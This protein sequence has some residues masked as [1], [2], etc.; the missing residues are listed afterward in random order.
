MGTPRWFLVV[1]TIC[2]LVLTVAGTVHLRYVAL[3][4]AVTLDTWSARACSP[5]GECWSV[6]R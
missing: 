3:G 5:R 2:A 6:R 1:L 4:E